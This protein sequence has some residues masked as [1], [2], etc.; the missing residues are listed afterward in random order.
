[1]ASLAESIQQLEGDLAARPIRI[2]AHSDMP[3][4]VLCYPPAEEFV[5]RKHL[6]LVAI[7]L[8]QSHGRSVTFIS[9]ARLVWDA[10]R[11]FG[12]ADL[13]KTESLRGFDAGQKHVNRLLTSS[14]FRPVEDALLEKMDGLSPEKDVVFLVRAGGFAP[15]IYR[16]SQ[17]LD[18]LHHRTLVPTILFYPGSAEVGTD[19]RFYDLPL[20]GGPGVY[21][22]R[23]KVYGVRS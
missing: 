23:V 7:K 15:Y 3:F 11:A 2:A 4:A 22:Y 10:I 8:N 16:S 12:Q 5:L 6:R 19:L 9:I 14:D 13:F 18:A 21:N 1:M 20:K 17:L